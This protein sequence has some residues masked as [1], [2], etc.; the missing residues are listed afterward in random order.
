MVLGHGDHETSVLSEAGFTPSR[1]GDQEGAHTQTGILRL[2]T[3]RSICGHKGL[4]EISVASQDGTG[5][6]ICRL[7]ID[8][9]VYM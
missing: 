3:V 2:E 6:N 8:V 7:R 9:V 5:V 1:H 4:R